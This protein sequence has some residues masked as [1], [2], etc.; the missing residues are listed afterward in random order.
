MRKHNLNYAIIGLFV[1]GTLTALVVVFALMTGRTGSTDS[2][3]IIFDNVADVK[4]GT[5]VRF[6]GYPIGTV[7]G[8]APFTDDGGSRFRLTI[9]VEEGWRIPADSIARIGSSS[10]LGAR[11]IDIVRGA[12][13][14]MVAP[15]GQISSEPSTDIFSAITR[16]ADEI[17]DVNKELLRPLLADLAKSVHTIG[18]ELETFSRSLNQSMAMVQQ[19]ITQENTD[20]ANVMIANFADMSDRLNRTSHTLDGLLVRVDALIENNRGNVSAG[21]EDFRYI[22]R[23]VA[24]NIDTINQNLD[25]AS[26]NLNEFSRRIRNNPG[27]LLGGSPREEVGKDARGAPLRPDANPVQSGENR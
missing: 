10:F 4:F 19:V 5:Q 1:T 13:E 15:R 3:D 7:E 11:T 14:T 6:E 27:L 9:G 2:Y 8:I 23:S 18:G 24:Q 12:S 21:L 20:H 22:L 26:R 16:V 17:S 25:G